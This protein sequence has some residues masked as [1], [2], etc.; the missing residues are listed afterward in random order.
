MK[1][2]LVIDS[3]CLS[4]F[5]LSEMVQQLSGEFTDS[6]IE[7]TSFNTARK[8][9]QEIGVSFLPTWLINNEI[10]PIN[11]FDYKSLRKKI[12]ERM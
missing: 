12:E 1:I 9:M 5:S 10:I 4:R 11:P 7:I 6:E 3:A 8:R 2:E